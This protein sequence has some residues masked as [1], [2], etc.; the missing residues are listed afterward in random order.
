M[1]G[2]ARPGRQCDR[3]ASRTARFRCSSSYGALGYRLAPRNSDDIRVMGDGRILRVR[4]SPD[5]GAG[6]TALLALAAVWSSCSPL[7]DAPAPVLIANVGEEGE[8]NL[9]GMRYL[10]RGTKGTR[11]RAFLVLDGPN[12]EHVT[13]RALASRR[14]EVTLTGPGGHSWNDHGI[15]NPVHA[16]SRAITWFT[17]QAQELERQAGEPRS[18][19]NFGILQ[20]GTSINSIPAEAR[21]KVDLRSERQDRMD[22][23]A[24]LLAATVEKAVA[25]ENSRSNTERGTGGRVAAREGWRDRFPAGRRLGLR[26]RRAS[27]G[28]SAGGQR[29]SGN[30]HPA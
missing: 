1:G 10:C 2:E 16:L 12:S 17:E 14:F 26:R 25:W 21:A 11:Y 6:L 22:L 13:W 4:A 9:C 29:S 23:L 19:F 5:N 7:A 24:R 3:N 8:G 20:G 28:N 15:G 30:P 18:S 27:A